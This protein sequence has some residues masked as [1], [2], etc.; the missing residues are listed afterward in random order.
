MY[1][2]FSVL[3]LIGGILL[4]IGDILFDL[5]GKGNEK[6]GTS[7]NIDSNW[8]KMSDWRFGASIVF[9]M[10]GD[11]MAG[12]GIFSLGMQIAENNKILGYITVG[13]GWFGTIAGLFI[14][15]VLCIQALIYKG[16]MERG[17]FEIA[18][19]ALNR[20][21]K[22]IYFPFF[23]G[24]IVLMIPQITEVIAIFTKAIDVPIF[25]TLL[26]SIVFLIFG[27]AMRKINPVKFQDLPGIIMPSMGLAMTGLIGIL[28]LM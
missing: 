9:A 5:K 15:S 1:M 6:L 28:N 16:I 22:Q 24:Y 13:C 14:H 26:N 18:D 27:M 21:Y 19:D 23:L 2:T 8:L 12:L 7:G 4:A 10:F 11:F 3:G 20:M 25:C 17:N